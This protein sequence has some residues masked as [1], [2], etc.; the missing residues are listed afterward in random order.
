MWRRETALCCMAARLQRLAVAATT[1]RPLRL[2]AF[3]RAAAPIALLDGSAIALVPVLTRPSAHTCACSAR[4]ICRHTS[5]TLR[6]HL[7]TRSPAAPHRAST[8]P[9]ALAIR[10]HIRS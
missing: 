4:R 8:P 1:M 9:L 6:I 3:R 10:T 7:P 2:F 5:R